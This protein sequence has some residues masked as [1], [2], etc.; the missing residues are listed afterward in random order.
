MIKEKITPR[1]SD[2]MSAIV[3]RPTRRQNNLKNLLKRLGNVPAERVLLD[4]LPG[5]ATEADLIRLMDGD[6][7]HLC[8]LVDNTLVEKPMGHNESRMSTGLSYYFLK[9]L[10][11]HDVGYM[12]GESGSFHT[13]GRNIRMP[14]LSFISWKH[15]PNKKKDLVKYP[16]L[17]FAP[18]LVVEVLSKSNTKQEIAQKLKEYLT[19]G[20][21]LV[22]IVDPKKESVTIHRLDGSSEILTAKDTLSGEDVLPGLEIP[23]SEAF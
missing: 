14:D 7:K 20:I 19:I 1:R 22:W 17:P 23:V 12:A 13:V 6:D 16:V 11:A 10:K 18:E 8:E 5:Q 4:P 21:K 9:Y 3:T 2:E 15:F